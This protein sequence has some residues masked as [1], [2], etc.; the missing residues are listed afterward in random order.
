MLLQDPPIV[1]PCITGQRRGDFLTDG[2][3][4]MA[5]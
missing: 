3:S 5:Y 2:R 4:E 1:I